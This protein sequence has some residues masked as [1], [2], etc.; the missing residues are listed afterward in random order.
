MEKL[1]DYITYTLIA[2]LFFAVVVLFTEQGK[3]KDATDRAIDLVGVGTTANDGTGDALR[4]AFIKVNT[5]LYMLDSLGIDDT[6]AEDF[7]MLTN[8]DLDS[9][10]QSY[11]GYYAIYDGADTLAPHIPDAYTDDPYDL[12]PE[13][14]A[15]A[16]DTSNYATPDKIGDFF[17]NTS[18][19]KL[20]V[21]V[22]AARNGWVI[23]N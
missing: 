5:A 14:H 4:T 7:T 15:F 19:S 9:L 17:I 3:Q 16:G 21:S 11:T 23:L 18:T 1:R 20:Y 8:I 2:I 10:A 22:T 13:I 6:N 12:F